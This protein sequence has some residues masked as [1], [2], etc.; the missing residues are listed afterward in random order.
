MVPG[1]LTRT[2]GH[3]GRENRATA[4]RRRPP[5]LAET[6][7]SLALPFRRSHRHAP[8]QRRP[9]RSAEPGARRSG[10]PAPGTTWIPS[11]EYYKS[12]RSITVSD[13]NTYQPR[14]LPN[15]SESDPVSVL[16]TG[17]VILLRAV[18][19]RARN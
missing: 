5:W 12:D 7:L 2:H 15:T 1:P 16:N 10:P 17:H 14:C 8:R 3:A 11:T 18:S 6:F 19:R 13:R 9:R 4:P